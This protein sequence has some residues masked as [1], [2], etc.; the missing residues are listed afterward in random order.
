MFAVT[1]ADH[2]EA[3]AAPAGKGPPEP[4]SGHNTRASGPDQRSD[5]A[6]GRPASGPGVG[7]Q[8]GAW[9]RDLSQGLAGTGRTGR[10]TEITVPDSPPRP[11]GGPGLVP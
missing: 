9:G 7:F 4:G 2:S 3:A 10:D 5:T 6:M 8:V 1:S 11:A